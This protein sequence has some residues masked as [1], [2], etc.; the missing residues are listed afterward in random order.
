MLPAVYIV[1]ESL[2]V[3]FRNGENRYQYSA[4][5][6]EN[7]FHNKFRVKANIYSITEVVY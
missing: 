4:H 5:E 6:I 2:T 3:L 7:S 1:I